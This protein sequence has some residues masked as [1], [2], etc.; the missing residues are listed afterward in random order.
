M[1]KTRSEI[2][3]EEMT[4]D[5]IFLLQTTRGRGAWTVHSVWLTREEAEADGY[6]A[7][8]PEGKGKSWMVYCICANGTLA[9]VLKTADEDLRA[10]VEELRTENKRLQG[11]LDVLDLDVSETGLV[12]SEFENQRDEARKELERLQDAIN[13]EAGEA[14]LHSVDFHGN[15]MEIVMSH[16][17]FYL[18]T[19]AFGDYWLA[20]GA[21][22]YIEIEMAS[23]RLPGSFVVRFERV[24]GKAPNVQV[25]E[26]KAELAQVRAELEAQSEKRC[27]WTPV[28]PYS[29]S[30]WNTSCGETWEFTEGGPNENRVLFCQRCGCKVNA[31]FAPAEYDEEEE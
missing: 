28:D 12:I 21:K 27:E 20:L 25:Q 26:L 8:G 31:V 16:P 6:R 3:R 30:T 19:K 14:L 1:T 17:V 2:S 13:H 9:D 11:D 7:Y 5:P 10:K 22:N 15:S 18:F 4:R 24:G 29:E 23:P